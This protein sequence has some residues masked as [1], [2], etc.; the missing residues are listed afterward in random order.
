MKI[1][2]I[3]L[4]HDGPDAIDCTV[5]TNRGEPGERLYAVRVQITQIIDPDEPSAEL[6]GPSAITRIETTSIEPE[7]ASE[8]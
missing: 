2:I 4:D 8:R 6:P 7:G 1:D 5:V 3:T